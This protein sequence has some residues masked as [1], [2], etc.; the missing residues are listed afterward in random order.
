VHDTVKKIGK[1]REK[2]GKKGKIVRVQNLAIYTILTSRV[3]VA[4]Y[5]VQLHFSNTSKKA[6]CLYFKPFGQNPTCEEKD[7]IS[8]GQKLAI[9]ANIQLYKI[10]QLYN[11]DFTS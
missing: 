9:F 6:R 5:L 1:T 3:D 10:I 11:S 8:R 2:R 4:G 7:K